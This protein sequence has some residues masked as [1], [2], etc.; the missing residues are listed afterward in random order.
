[1]WTPAGILAQADP[2]SL[3]GRAATADAGQPRSR[4]D[5]EILLPLKPQ[6]SRSP[7]FCVHPG[8]GLSWSY[9]SLRSYL[10]PDY[11]LYGLQAR[12][13]AWIEPLPQTLEEM[14]ADYIR[15]IRSVQPEGPYSLLGWSFGG[16]VAQAMA[17]QLRDMGEQIELL[18]ILDG[19]PQRAGAF[20]AD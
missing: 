18:A 8:A 5:F 14:A 9:A 20:I 4:G 10:P 12:G 19:Y 2:A 13:L 16:V 1:T 11:P 15:Q 17:T 7:L 6:G 3:G